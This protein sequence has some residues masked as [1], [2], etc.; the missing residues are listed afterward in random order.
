MGACRGK[1]ALHHCVTPGRGLLLGDVSPTAVKR[2]DMQ[3]AVRAARW[4][5]R[6]RKSRY[7]GGAKAGSATSIGYRNASL[8]SGAVSGCKLRGVTV[9][10]NQRWLRN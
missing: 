4:P 9:N 2:C 6:G 3:A 5:V 7:V 8:R 1:S 10:V